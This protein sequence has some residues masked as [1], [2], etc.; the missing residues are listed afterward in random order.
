[1]IWTQDLQEPKCSCVLVRISR[2]KEEKIGF[3]ERERETQKWDTSRPK[4]EIKT[5]PRIWAFP[6]RAKPIPARTACAS[7]TCGFPLPHVRH[8]PAPPHACVYLAVC[9]PLKNP[10]SPH[11]RLG[12]PHVRPWPNWPKFSG[13]ALGH[14]GLD[15]ALSGTGE[16]QSPNK[17][18]NKNFI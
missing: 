6:A 11:V 3:R 1:M 5:E 17:N 18:K 4:R 10:L 12:L 15:R 7:R 8:L 2:E 9:N 13:S 14:P 16:I